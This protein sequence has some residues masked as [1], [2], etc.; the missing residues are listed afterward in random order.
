MPHLNL[1]I[2]YTIGV[3]IPG[4]YQTNTDKEYKTTWRLCETADLDPAR[5][6]RN[7]EVEQMLSDVRRGFVEQGE[8]PY[9]LKTDLDRM[10]LEESLNHHFPRVYLK[11][12]S[13]VS[14][15]DNEIDDQALHDC[16]W[17]LTPYDRA[18][19][20]FAADFRTGEVNLILNDIQ[21]FLV[22][23]R[24]S[25]L[26]ILFSRIIKTYDDYSVN[27]YEAHS[28]PGK[29]SKA[30]L[31]NILDVLDKK[32]QEEDRDLEIMKLYGQYL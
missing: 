27:T 23:K 30:T 4:V 22:S 3:T 15:R 16:N 21:G 11:M 25:H 29:P 9:T 1:E 8:L 7:T 19:E 5:I 28:V 2:Q 24:E 10:D 20:A 18:N 32:I 6:F 12:H 14:F 17:I 26:K 13:R 31:R